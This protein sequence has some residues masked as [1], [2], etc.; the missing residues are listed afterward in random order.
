MHVEEVTRNTDVEKS[1]ILNTLELTLV[2]LC[3]PLFGN[4][5]DANAECLLQSHLHITVRAVSLQL[6]IP[7]FSLE[8]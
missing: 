1:G 6:N 2:L 7:C 5:V 3:D 4:F 8:F